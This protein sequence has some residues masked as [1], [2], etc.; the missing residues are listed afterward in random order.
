M[1]LNLWTIILIF[2]LMMQVG[3]QS[4]STDNGLTAAEQA[5]LRREKNVDGRIKIYDRASAR[6]SKDLEAQ[7]LKDD[8]QAV[9][10]TLKAWRQLLELAV[11][12]IDQN[13]SRKKKS[14]DLIRCE[15]QL[16]KQISNVQ[17]IKIRA[18]LDQQSDFD[19]W[20]GRAEEVRKKFVEI[21]FPG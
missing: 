15:I 18:P 1:I 10:D 4:L 16:R 5:A 9:P 14:R 20:L 2:G 17:G 21:I 6:W 8:F 13:A 19:A 3:A 11:K 12:D 7:T